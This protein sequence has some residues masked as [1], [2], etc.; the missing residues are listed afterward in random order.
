[1]PCFEARS[2]PEPCRA[3]QHGLRLHD[4]CTCH[5]HEPPACVTHHHVTG[6]CRL[7]PQYCTGFDNHCM[8]VGDDDT[9]PDVGIGADTPP[10]SL[11]HIA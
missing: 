7:E 4:R 6:Q 8:A 3:T 1:M 10:Q 11:I 9:R 2:R 5:D